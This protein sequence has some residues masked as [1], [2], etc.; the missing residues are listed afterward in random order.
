MKLFGTVIAVLF[1]PGSASKI[2]GKNLT[3][4]GSF[5]K[6]RRHCGLILCMSHVYVTE[7]RLDLFVSADNFESHRCE[8]A[9]VYDS[10]TTV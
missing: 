10:R 7:V 5:S 4:G 8:S 9:V 3:D 1:H 6:L 2:N